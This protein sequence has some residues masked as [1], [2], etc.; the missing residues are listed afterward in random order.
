MNFEIK[1]QYLKVLVS[2]HGGELQSLKKSQEDYEYLWQGSPEFWGRRAPILFPIVGKLL[3]DTYTYKGKSYH[4]TQ[5]G[6]ARD[7]TFDLYHAT[8]D[9]IALLLRDNEETYKK[10]PF[11]FELLL[12]YTLE[13]DKLVVGYHV[14]N[15]ESETMPFSIGAHPAF[16]WEEN[17]TAHF[18][19]ETDFI[20]SL[21][22]TPNG[23]DL[24]KTLIATPEGRLK[25][26][27][28]LFKNDAL[29]LEDTNQVTFVNGDR[30]VSMTFEGFPYLG[31]WSKPTGAPF[32]CIEPWHGLADVVGHKGEILEKKGIIHLASG[33]TFTSQYVIKIS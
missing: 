11:N 3:E 2:D 1:N 7:M 5:H 18:E 32:V 4:M 23:I 30:R 9:S 17:K 20:E 6:F 12:S 29:I 26:D 33:M 16:N 31:L 19:F 24:N 21:I 14:K 27:Q 13:G 10:Y 25:I 22:L 15:M 28:R 8:E